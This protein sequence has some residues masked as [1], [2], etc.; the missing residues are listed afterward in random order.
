MEEAGSV[1][2]TDKMQRSFTPETHRERRTIF[3]P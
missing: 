3:L 2:L 1:D